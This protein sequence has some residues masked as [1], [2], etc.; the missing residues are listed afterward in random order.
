MQKPTSPRIVKSFLGCAFGLLTTQATAVSFAAWPTTATVAT[1]DQSSTFGEN[2]S[3]LFY[4]P[5]AASNAAVLWA[6]QNSPSKLYR[7]TWNGANYVKNTTNS[8]GNGKTLRFPNGSGAPDA[9]G[10]TMAELDSTAVYVASER[11]GSGASRLSILRYDTGAT[12]S[13]LKASNEWNLTADLPK[14]D[15]NAGLE[16]ITW[17][18]DS[19]LQASQFIDE[20]TRLPYDPANYPSHGTGLFLV[21]LEANGQIYAYALN[22]SGS[23]YVRVATVASG[24]SQIMDLS[25]DRDNNILWAA[26]DNNCSGKTTL[27]SVDTTA[28]SPTQGK[29]V[30][31]KGYNRP[32]S[33]SNLNNEGIAIAPESECTNKLKTFIWADDGEDNK[34][35]LRRGTISCGPQF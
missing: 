16:S 22:Q 10:V 32:G 27:L 25:F 28:G 14:V 9:E 33:M 11:D 6:V 1:A 19:Y 7:L 21:G 34:H 15:S 23:S 4:Q 20:N 8:W 31:R 3:G 2:L 29:F 5:A 17:V 18:P 13:T 30:V 35:A 12:G 26:C 24:Q